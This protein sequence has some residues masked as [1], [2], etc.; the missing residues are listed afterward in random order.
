MRV[1]KAWVPLITKKVVEGIVSKQLIKPLVPKE[2]LL[3][4]AEEIVMEELTV[5]DRLNEEVRE[6]LKKHGIEIER[7]KLD[8]RK[9]F[10]LTKQKVARERNLIL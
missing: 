1:P 7:S 3:S 10:E 5:E 8:Y 4:V 9:L 6:I 2:K